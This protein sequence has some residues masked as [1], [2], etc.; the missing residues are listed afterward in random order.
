MLRRHSLRKVKPQCH[1]PHTFMLSACLGPDRVDSEPSSPRSPLLR[2]SDLLFTTS[3]ILALL[4]VIVI[5]ICWKLEVLAK[6]LYQI[7]LLRPT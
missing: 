4:M 1:D 2:K 7:K 3:S 5:Y 6:L